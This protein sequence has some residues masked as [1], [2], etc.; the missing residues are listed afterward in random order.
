MSVWIV[1]ICRVSIETNNRVNYIMGL[2][3]YLQRY[4]HM[5]L[6]L[7]VTLII[8]YL[9]FNTLLFLYVDPLVFMA[10]VL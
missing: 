2:I 10:F 7:H 1:I 9:Q 4:K 8:Y 6:H 3:I 5:C